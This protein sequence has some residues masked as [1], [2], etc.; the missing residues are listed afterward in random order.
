MKT[1]LLLATLACAAIPAFAGPPAPA[2]KAVV[3]PPPPVYGTGW[4]GAIQA[5][6]APTMRD[7]IER[8]RAAIESGAAKDR[9][10]RV[11]AFTQALAA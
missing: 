7:G 2:S 5:G 11:L 9:L 10:D 8:A 4:Y 1:N 6:V 3:P